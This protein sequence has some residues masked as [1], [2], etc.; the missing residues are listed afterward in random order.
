MAI[1][2]RKIL[3]KCSNGYVLIKKQGSRK[4]HKSIGFVLVIRLNSNQ[5]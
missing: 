5:S 3:I 2:M 4:N 1:E